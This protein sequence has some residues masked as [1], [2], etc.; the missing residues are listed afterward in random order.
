MKK[1][2]ELLL[3]KISPELQAKIIVLVSTIVI[4]VFIHILGTLIMRFIFGL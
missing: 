4:G 3:I 2:I 1:I